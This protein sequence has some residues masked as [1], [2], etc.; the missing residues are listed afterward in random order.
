MIGD[1][2]KDRIGDRRKD[3]IGDRG[4]DRIWKKIGSKGDRVRI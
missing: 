1:R 4:Y 2:R 3:R